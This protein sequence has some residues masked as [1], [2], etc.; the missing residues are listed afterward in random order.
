MEPDLQ[1]YLKSL[2]N[3]KPRD[4]ITHSEWSHL[5]RIWYRIVDIHRN[6]DEIS[7]NTSLDDELAPL[8][9]NPANTERNKHIIITSKRR[10]DVI[11]TCLLRSVCKHGT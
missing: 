5:V 1:T 8:D 11:I 4:F 3:E 10:F 7:I 2:A 9:T 6:L